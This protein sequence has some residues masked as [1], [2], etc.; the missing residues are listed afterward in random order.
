MWGMGH[1]Q[2]IVESGIMGLTVVDDKLDNFLGKFKI[3]GTR[4]PSINK[5]YVRY[6]DG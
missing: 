1:A 6:N 4:F 2:S 3:S 5:V